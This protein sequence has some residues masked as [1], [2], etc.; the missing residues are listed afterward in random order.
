M[1]ETCKQIVVTC[2]TFV[3][4]QNSMRTSGKNYYINPKYKI[5]FENFAVEVERSVD[6]LQK[7]LQSS[8]I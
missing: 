5:N 1:V 7:V 4:A 6:D 2:A 3:P 8:C